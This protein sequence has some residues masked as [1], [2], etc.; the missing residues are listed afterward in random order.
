MSIAPLDG[1]PFGPAVA[2]ELSASTETASSEGS[3]AEGGQDENRR[4]GRWCFQATSRTE[5]SR[6][7]AKFHRSRLASTTPACS[8]IEATVTN[9]RIHVNLAT[10]G[11]QEGRARTD[12]MGST[13]DRRPVRPPLTWHLSGSAHLPA[14]DLTDTVQDLGSDVAGTFLSHLR[15]PSG[16]VEARAPRCCLQRSS[17]KVSRRPTVCSEASPSSER[18]IS[19]PRSSSSEISGDGRALQS[20]ASQTD[21]NGKYVLPSPLC[22]PLSKGR[23]HAPAPLI[24]HLQVY[25]CSLAIL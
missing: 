15:S 2:G 7:P 4:S 11:R 24:W 12:R 22:R 6:V 9:F 3:S 16:S 25:G 18:P 17:G 23:R 5:L 19:S 1:A 21:P 20:R 13:K 14:L 8:E 10:P